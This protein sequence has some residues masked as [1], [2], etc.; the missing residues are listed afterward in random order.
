MA[1]NT[2]KADLC[3][4][5]GRAL[6]TM[7]VEAVT[8]FMGADFEEILFANLLVKGCEGGDEEDSADNA[9]NNTQSH[10]VLHPN[11][12]RVLNSLLQVHASI[13]EA[14]LN[15][16]FEKDPRKVNNRADYED[17]V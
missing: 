5:A 16:Q 13:R 17:L 10:R 6:V 12:T 14:S 15:H 4:L 1:L 9:R 2:A 11:I 3:V 7:V 8:T